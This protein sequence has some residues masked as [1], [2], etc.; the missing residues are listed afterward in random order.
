MSKVRSTAAIASLFV[1]CA[2]ALVG[3]GANADPEA[4]SASSL[5]G[6]WSAS[7][8]GYGSN[9]LE[10]GFQSTFVINK[11]D[12]SSQSFAGD[13]SVSAANAKKYDIPATKHPF[14]GEVAPWGEI[15]MVH[16]EGTWTLE[17][18]GNDKM[19]G[20]Y[21]ETGNDLA[22]KSITLTRQK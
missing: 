8:A 20:T 4:P 3:C 11:A 17:M 21:L 10:E 12:D 2:V 5:V 13:R 15:S 18:D 7:V 6:T 9:G 16:K 14:V 22:A 19:V 1:I